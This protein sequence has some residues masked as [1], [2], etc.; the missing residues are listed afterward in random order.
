MCIF[1][2][3]LCLKG[4][5]I[6]LLMSESN[7]L[8]TRN[9]HHVRMQQSFESTTAPSLI[10]FSFLT[11]LSVREALVSPD[12]WPSSIFLPPTVS[13]TQHLSTNLLS[14]FSESYLT[15]SHN[16]RLV[17]DA[18]FFTRQ[19]FIKRLIL[20]PLSKSSSIRKHIRI[21]CFAGYSCLYVDDDAFLKLL[22]ESSI[23]E[24]PK[25]EDFKSSSRDSIFLNRSSTIRQR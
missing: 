6:T 7:H 18:Q 3:P 8:S 10:P 25:S 16:T 11:R 21:G 23:G 24:P 14:F 5:Q 12:Y 22:I 17:T 15:C 13:S 4:L 19:D 2:F 20:C 9:W 1:E